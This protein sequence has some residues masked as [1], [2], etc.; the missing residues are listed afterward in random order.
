[1]ERTL[2]LIA[3]VLLATA[4]TTLVYT[5]RY[6]IG[7]SAVERGQR[8]GD[9]KRFTDVHGHTFE[10]ELVR[11]TWTPLDSQLGLILVNKTD[12][13]Q[14]VIWDEVTYAGPDGKS[15]RVIH[16]GVNNA[17][18]GASMPPTEIIRGGTLLDL[19]EP[20]GHIESR[21]GS[22]RSDRPLIGSTSGSTER[23]VRSNMV[24]GTIKVLLPIES[25]GTIHEY[26]FQ[27][28]VGGSVVLSGWAS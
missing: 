19:I 26:T 9:V 27:F 13:S 16:E 3:V 22:V 4:C 10:D 20:V 8:G 28:S 2:A 24:H 17:D 7:L 1:M 21:M 12:S 5:A 25:N 14:R 15:D 23:E 11:I 6:D 18:R